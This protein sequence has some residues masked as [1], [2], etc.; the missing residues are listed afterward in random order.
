MDWLK[1]RMETTEERISE[2]EDRT[3]EITQMNNRDKRLET[4][5]NKIKKR[6]REKNGTLETHGNITKI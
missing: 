4:K 6:K 2:L 3:I 1:G 5:Q